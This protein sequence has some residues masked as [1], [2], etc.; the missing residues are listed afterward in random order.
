MS[1]YHPQRYL[2]E[3]LGT[4]LLTAAV[5]TSFMSGFPLPTLAVAA[6]TLGTIVYMVGSVSGAHVNP[7]ITIGLFSLRKITFRDALLYVVCQL[8][9]AFLATMLLQKL[10]TVELLVATDT[11]EAIVG[12]LIGAF[13]FAA[14]VASV[15][16]GRVHEAAS[17]LAVGVS[18]FLGITLASSGSLGIINP[19]VAIGIGAI[20]PVYLLAPVVGALGGMQFYRWMIGSKK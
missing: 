8:I 10:I 14:G 19:A 11:T 7:A 2:A 18:L 20:S 17:G 16:Y 1:T 12:E 4:F 5:L 6:I 9:G 3:M 15:V 13:V